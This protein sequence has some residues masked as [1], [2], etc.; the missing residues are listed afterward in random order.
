MLTG[1][2]V[3]V[4][5]LAEC[6]RLLNTLKVAAVDLCLVVRQRL[7][8]AFLQVAETQ[9]DKYQ[10]GKHINSGSNRARRKERDGG[11]G[12]DKL[13]EHIQFVLNIRNKLIGTVFDSSPYEHRPPGAIVVLH[14]P[15]PL[16]GGVVHNVGVRSP[17]RHL[18]Q[19][20]VHKLLP[21]LRW[22]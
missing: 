17:E 3:R 20:V 11:H 22:T 12:S 15:G 1:G 14:Q 9:T 21:L 5:G 10:P 2:D 6:E 4:D 16:F 18:V 8:Q 13:V 7:V 19:H